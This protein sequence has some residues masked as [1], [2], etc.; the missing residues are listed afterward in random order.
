VVTLYTMCLLI[1]LARGVTS[2]YQAHSICCFDHLLE[3]G[4]E[5][6]LLVSIGAKARLYWLLA[7]LEEILKSLRMSL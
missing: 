2:H 4:I 7:L 3:M 1:N 5:H 6:T